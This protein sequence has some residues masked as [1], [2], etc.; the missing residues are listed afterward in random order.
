MELLLCQEEG[1]H[2]KKKCV[3]FSKWAS[4][5]FRICGTVVNKKKRQAPSFK[6]LGS[7]NGP[8]AF[9]KIQEIPCWVGKGVV[10]V[11]GAVCVC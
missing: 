3:S 1:A 7:E 2:C 11:S 9:S 10:C 4:S 8:T 6:F 5:F